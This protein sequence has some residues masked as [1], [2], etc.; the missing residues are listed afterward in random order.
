MVALD[1]S[2]EVL[3]LIFLRFIDHELIGLLHVDIELL[4]EVRMCKECVVDFHIA[5][6]VILLLVI[7]FEALA[8]LL[9]GL[10][11]L[12]LQLLKPLLSLLH[13]YLLYA[14]ISGK[15]NI[16]SLFYGR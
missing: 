10:Q 5:V 14:H 2:H 15:L 11:V 4:G 6:M 1:I 13:I 12:G 3:D 7:F 8:Q 9:V 16:R